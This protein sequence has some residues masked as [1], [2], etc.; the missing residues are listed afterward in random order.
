[1]VDKI[2]AFGKPRVRFGDL[3]R[4]LAG[5]EQRAHRGP[6]VR[7]YGQRRR[8]LRAFGGLLHGA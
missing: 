8:D 6:Q 1:M 3:H 7:A 2:A 4:Q 5:G